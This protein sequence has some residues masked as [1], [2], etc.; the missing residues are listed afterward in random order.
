MKELIFRCNDKQIVSGQETI[1]CGIVNVTPDSFSDGGKWYGTEQAVRHALE[2]IE[3]GAR[4]IDLGGE[5]TRPGSTPVSAEDEIRRVVPVIRELKQKTDVM[6][7]IDTWKAEVAEAC[8]AAGIDIINDITGLV[9]DPKMARTVADS[10]AGVIVMFNP[11]IVRPQHAGSKIFPSFGGEGVF[12]AKELEK[13]AEAPIE[14]AMVLYFE[15][16]L[17][18]AAQNGIAKDRI[19]LDP[20]IGFGQTKRENLSLI[21]HAKIMHDMGYPIFLGVSRKRFIV[22]LLTEEG[23]NLDTETEEGFANRDWGSAI[24]TAI[25]ARSGIEVV[26]VHSIKEHKIAQ[27]IADAVRMSDGMEDT[28]FGQY[29]N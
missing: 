7:S 9:G 2:L 12:S 5:S 24:L 1:L 17:D 28:N 3:Q 8:I 19:M 27:S 10:E 20:G 15:R 13:M 21:H 22:N 18:I 25:A 26:R 23:F 4:M 16:A 14:E 6:L 11:V 29:K